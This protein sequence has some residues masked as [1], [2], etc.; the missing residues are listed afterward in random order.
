MTRRLSAKERIRRYLRTRVGNVVTSAQ[1]QEA[2]GPY[3]TEWARRVRELRDE[4]G[5]QIRTHIDDGALKPGQYRLESPPPDRSEY[6]FSRPVSTRLRAQVLER[7][8][9]TCQMCGAGAGDSDPE[10]P[11]R[12]VRLQIGHIK[13]RSQGGLD[14][15]S[16]LRALCS[17]CNQGARNLVQEPPSWAWLL[18]QLRRASQDD[19]R[20]SLEW[21]QNKFGTIEEQ[22]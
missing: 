11:G 6:Q 1:L 5:W 9:Y 13:D 3:V 22:D 20:R 8:G 15:L 4:E 12:T 17:T 21:L 16:N 18:G 19:Q 14:E 2:A 7:N 10:M